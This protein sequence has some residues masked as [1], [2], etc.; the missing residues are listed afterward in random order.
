MSLEVTVASLRL[1][2]PVMNASGI[3]GNTPGGII[4]LVKLGFSAIVT[5]TITLEPREGFKPPTIARLPTGGLINAVGLANPGK[6]AI[7]ELVDTAKKLSVPIVVSIAGKSESEF[8]E[9]ACE[10]QRVGADALELNL[11][12]PHTEGYGIELGAD[13]RKVRS[14]V[15]AVAST[16]SIPVLAKL[17]LSDKVVEAAGK[18]LE[19]G[20]E[21]LVLINTIK[22]MYIDVY[23]L[24]P[25]LTAVYGGLSGPPIHPVAVRVVYDVYKEYGADIIGVGGILDWKTAAEFIVAGAKAVQVGTALVSNDR[26][27]EEILE[28]FRKWLQQLSAG[29]IA[30]LVG[31]AHKA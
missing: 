15:G 21:G 13:P 25:V 28:G 11:S 31:A 6:G 24:R 16:T 4:K 5:K 14:V 19:A 17:G 26:I 23:A 2:H 10:A 7:K 18:A 9:V 30:E 1:N 20:A 22:A 8:A 12:C 3:L 27:V 29:S